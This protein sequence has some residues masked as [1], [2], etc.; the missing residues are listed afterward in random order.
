M[1]KQMYTQHARVRMAQR[2]IQQYIVEMVMDEGIEQF[3]NGGTV[4]FCSKKVC[5]V[6]FKK[7]APRALVERCQG[8]YVIVCNGLVVTAAHSYS[9][10]K[11]H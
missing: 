11:K 9:R 7:K 2:G 10:V 5:K 1:G 6:L 3:C 4:Y 8:V